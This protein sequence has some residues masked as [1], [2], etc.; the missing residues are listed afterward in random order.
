MQEISIEE[1]IKN[2]LWAYTIKDKK[3]VLDYLGKK[4]DTIIGY[5]L[6][7]NLK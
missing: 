5:E 6:E 1:R 7:I 2:G 3:I 4:D